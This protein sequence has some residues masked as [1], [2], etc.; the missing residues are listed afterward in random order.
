MM[1]KLSRNL[2]GC[3]DTAIVDGDERKFADS[4]EH[5]QKGTGKFDRFRTPRLDSFDMEATGGM[6]E[7]LSYSSE[8]DMAS[9][10][11]DKFH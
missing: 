4:G 6:V 3:S 5:L 11:G 1:C 8:L 9:I 7:L 10:G 2:M